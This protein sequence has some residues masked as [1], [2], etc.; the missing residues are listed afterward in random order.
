V[1]PLVAAADAVLLD[2]SD[3][4]AD[5]VLDALVDLVRRATTHDSL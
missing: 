1:A 4:D 5:A 3:L 2:T